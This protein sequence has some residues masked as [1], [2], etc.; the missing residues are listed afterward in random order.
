[1]PKNEKDLTG[2]VTGL[3]QS[4]TSTGRMYYKATIT[5]AAIQEA[6][7]ATAVM[8][9]NGNGEKVS[10]DQAKIVVKAWVNSDKKSDRSPDV[11]LT[12]EPPWE[13]SNADDDIPF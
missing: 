12:F 7:K 5:V 9:P 2:R 10:P 3:W 11:N 13:K 8:T 4:E 6:V 1:M